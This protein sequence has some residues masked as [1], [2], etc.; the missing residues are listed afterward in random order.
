MKKL[1]LT[2]AV[3][4][5]GLSA[6]AQWA[7]VG[8]YCNWSFQT[9]TEFTGDGNE[10]S[11]KIDHLTSGFKIVDITNNNWDIQYGTETPIKLGEEYVLDAKDGGPDPADMSFADGIFAV[12]NA[13][14]TWN[15]TNAT[16]KITGTPTE[17]EV[18][19]SVIYLV[20]QPQGW[21]ING[22]SMPLKME[23]NGVY[24]ATYKIAAGQAMFRFYKALGSWDLNSIGSQVD[25]NAI[26]ISLTDGAYRGECVEGKGSWNI[27]GWTGG[28]LTMV[29]NLN[30]M[31]VSFT[32]GEVEPGPEVPSGTPA[33][34]YFLGNVEGNSWNPENAIEA[35]RVDNGVF[36]FDSIVLH[37]DD[38]SGTAWFTFI[39]ELTS[40]WGVINDGSHRYGPAA[41]V[42]GA[43]TV[44]STTAFTIAGD[45][46]WNIP[47]GT[48]DFIVDFN[49][50][51]LTV[52]T[53]GA[54][55]ESIGVDLNAP[56]EYY[57]LQGVK[58]NNPEK[59]GIYVVKQGNKT[60][61]IVVR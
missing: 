29:V 16:L 58:V 3:G 34:L 49:T 27:S 1:L 9:A 24:S 43:L 45:A 25:D 4:L 48:Y 54:G 55:V 13:V 53:G 51:E 50:M 32:A 26:N 19:S 28:D 52:T 12:D 6:S 17:Q 35:S 10:L 15:P 61:K 21:D 23:S 41:G 8:N 2:A 11:C 59:G 7:V 36:T 57:N 22:D 18:D 47:D 60:S 14:V 31:T 46:S 40:D 37:N 5:L 20:G 38:A 42:D 39:N 30:D 44:G 56:A 33:H